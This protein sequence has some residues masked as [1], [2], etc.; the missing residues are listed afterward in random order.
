M[1]TAV[2]GWLCTLPWQPS[3][4]RGP[5]LHRHLFSKHL[6]SSTFLY[7]PSHSSTTTSITNLMYTCI[8][9][10]SKA[11]WGR[12]DEKSKMRIKRETLGDKKSTFS[13]VNDLIWVI[14]DKK[15][16]EKYGKWKR[17]SCLFEKLSVVMSVKRFKSLP[18]LRSALNLPLWRPP[19]NPLGKPGAQPLWIHHPVSIFVTVRVQWGHSDFYKY[20]ADQTMEANL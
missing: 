14:H 11:L 10:G 16:N 3:L 15:C 17:K 9:P 12:E 13:T 1:S 8:Q 7:H 4:T 18:C 5:S 20:W 2:T 19:H 6:F